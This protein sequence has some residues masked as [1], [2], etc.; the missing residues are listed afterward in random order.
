MG[1]FGAIEAE[2]S[3][4]RGEP[5]PVTDLDGVL[6]TALAAPALLSAVFCF[7]LFHSLFPLS[8]TH[9]DVTIRGKSQEG[10]P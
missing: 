9:N 2:P 10:N 5:D 3:T 4:V 6:T 7:G 8:S 1:F